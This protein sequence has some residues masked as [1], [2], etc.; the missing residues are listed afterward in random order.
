MY[1]V[2]SARRALSRSF[3]ANHPA[4]PAQE[5]RQ[6]DSWVQRLKRIVCVLQEL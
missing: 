4:N 6:L 2:S 5:V 3:L 1:V